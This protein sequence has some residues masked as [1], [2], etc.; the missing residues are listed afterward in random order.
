MCWQAG[1]RGFILQGGGGECGL[2]HALGA[3]GRQRNG[4]GRIAK[5][6]TGT[7][8]ASVAEMDAI[9]VVANSAVM[10]IRRD[11]HHCPHHPQE[12]E[13]GRNKLFKK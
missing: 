7:V 2:G 9:G 13:G 8:V 10:K 11:C 12:M 1:A 6:L 5:A 3:A 4:G